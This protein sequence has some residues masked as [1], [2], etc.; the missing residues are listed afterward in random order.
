LAVLTEFFQAAS[1]DEFGEFD[2]LEV[3][4]QCIDGFVGLVQAIEIRSRLSTACLR[5]ET[6]ALLVKHFFV[7]ICCYSRKLSKK[8]DPSKK[9]G[10]AQFIL[11]LLPFRDLDRRF[12]AVA[13]ERPA[14]LPFVRRAMIVF[15]MLFANVSAIDWDVALSEQNLRRFF[16]APFQF[17]RLPTWTVEL[18]PQFY[19][20]AHSVP[21]DDQSTDRGLC[22]LSKTPIALNDKQGSRQLNLEGLLD[23]L[24]HGVTMILV[25]AGERVSAVLMVSANPESHSWYLPSVYVNSDGN[26]DVGFRG[27]APLNLNRDRL[28]KYIDSLVTGDWLARP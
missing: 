6:L 20:L 21:I 15:L 25:I 13:Q 9:D 27:F 1:R 14:S 19:F 2:D 26:D 23:K 28:E 11:S 4:T 17:D 18:P 16:V 7:A 12:W 8:V 24:A 22:L 10:D 5:R 3:L